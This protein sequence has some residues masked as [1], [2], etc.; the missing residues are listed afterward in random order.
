[1][2]AIAASPRATALKTTSE[3]RR[4]TIRAS[5]SASVGRSAERTATSRRP[6]CFA[7]RALSAVDTRRTM[8]VTGSGDGKTKLEAG[9]T[10]VL[11]TRRGEA[12]DCSAVRKTVARMAT[13]VAA[14]IAIDEPAPQLPRH[15]LKTRTA[16]ALSAPAVLVF[17]KT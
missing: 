12:Q 5:G 11:D 15:G 17:T 6:R 3:P 13:D 8:T 1:M 10:F 16:G 14:L 9:L 7:A 4:S 2:R